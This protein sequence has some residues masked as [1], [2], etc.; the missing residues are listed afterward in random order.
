MSQQDNKQLNAFLHRRYAIRLGRRY[1]LAATGILFLGLMGCSK[2]NSIDAVVAQSRPPNREAPLNN[3]PTSAVTSKVVAANTKFGLKLFTVLNPQGNE[4]VFISPTS[5]AIALA[6]IYNGASDATQRAMAQTL[7][8]RGINLQELNAANAAILTELQNPDSDVQLNIANSLWVRQKAAIQPDFLQKQN[9]YKA[10]IAN[11]DFNAA[12]AVTTI[13]N[14][15]NQSTNGKINQIVAKINPDDV[16]FLL[17]ATYFKGKWTNEFDKNQTQQQPFFL[18]SGEQQHP[19][20]SQTGKYSYYENDQFQ[21]V[22]LPYGQNQR[23]SLYIF[24]PKQD[25]KTFYQDLRAENWEKWITQFS[26]RAGFIQVPRFQIDYET[27][28]NDSL[29]ALGMEVAFTDKANFS[30]I[31]E[32][33]AL[34]E[35]KHKTFVEVNEE[36]TEA[37][38]ATSV[39]VT[40]ISAQINNKQPFRMIVNRPFFCALRDNQTGIVLFMGSIAK[41]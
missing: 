11:L 19:M 8:L 31:G 26:K 41:P 29:K 5:I 38:A 16:L 17:N 27:Q 6:M 32:N 33:L 35:V 20:M 18:A 10:K 7:E 3:Q 21:A 28:L 15:V 1:V 9:F 36:G 30:G 37:A 2:L 13:N 40:L 14:W 23:L 24:L 12:D 34:S 25:S 22:S 39:G 4:N